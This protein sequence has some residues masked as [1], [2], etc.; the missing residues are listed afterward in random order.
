MTPDSFADLAYS[1][2]NRARP[3]VV[4]VRHIDTADVDACVDQFFE[5]RFVLSGG[6]DGK[7]DFRL[8]VGFFHKKMAVRLVS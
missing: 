1:A 4:G 6:T 2:D 8:I 7:N 5:S 3:L